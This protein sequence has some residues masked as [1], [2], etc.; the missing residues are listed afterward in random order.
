MLF[1]SSAILG[2]GGIATAVVGGWASSRMNDTL[3]NVLF[4]VLLLVV[5]LRLIADVRSRTEH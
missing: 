3:S 1:R 4:A 5:A 2:F